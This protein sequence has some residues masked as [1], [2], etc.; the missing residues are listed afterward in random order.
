MTD[1]SRGADDAAPAAP[2]GHLVP[3]RLQSLID[4]PGLRAAGEI[5]SRTRP[6]WQQALR[7]LAGGPDV[8]CHLELSAITFVDVA[9]VTDLAHAAQT[10]AEGRRIVLDRPPP[11]LRRVLEMFWPGLPTI[12]VV[13]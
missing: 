4:R 10:L 7:E 8:T 12:E 2:G 9:G 1:G 13:S 11:E 5:S 3:L 6:A